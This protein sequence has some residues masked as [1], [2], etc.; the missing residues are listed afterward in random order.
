MLRFLYENQQDH[1][2]AIDGLTP[3]H[4]TVTQPNNYTATHHLRPRSQ[5][6]ILCHSQRVHYSLEFDHHGNHGAQDKPHY[7]P[8]HWQKQKSLYACFLLTCLE[9]DL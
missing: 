2:S 8:S 9:E 6:H 7:S 5:Q 1:H 4:G 3:W